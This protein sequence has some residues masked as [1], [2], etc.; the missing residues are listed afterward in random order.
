ML[1]SFKDFDNLTDEINRREADKI[2]K[3][4]K[5]REEFN[6]ETLD[7]ACNC[8]YAL[9]DFQTFLN[10]NVLAIGSSGTGKTR[11]LV[12]PN[13]K[14]AVGSSI[15][16]DPKGLIYNKHKDFLEQRGYNVL[17][18]DLAHPERSMKYNPLD[19][20]KT[21]QDVMRISEIITDKK[22][23]LGTRADPYWDNM[24][25][26]YLNAMIGYIIETNELPRCFSSVLTLM[27][28]GTRKDEENKITPLSQRF[29]RLK[30]KNPQSWAVS[31]FL[32]A[33][34][35]PYK[36]YDTIRS[37]VAAKFA[38]LDTPELRAM[39]SGNDIDFKRIG[40]EKTAVFVTV[41]DT[42][43]SMDTLANIFVTQSLQQLCEHAN[44]FADGRLPVP[45]RFI[46]DDF[47]T[48]C[49]IAEFPRI[50]ST[51]RSRGIS[52][53]L[54]LQSEAQLTNYYGYD[55][56][57]VISNCDTYVYLGGNDLETA[58]SISERANKPL[59]QI[60]NMP[61]GFCWVFRRGDPPVF[62]RLNR[63]GG[64]ER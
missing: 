15:L 13:L 39:M 54:M 33:D 18:L 57:T 52:A 9:N 31:Q 2:R 12:E 28:E 41:S 49:R 5:D 19:F 6:K 42:D 20:V 25:N 17:L 3:Q 50:I 55:D 40:E 60:L 36:T 48:N 21:P 34:S 22:A 58:K 27:H 24:T 43:R 7:I 53:M 62:T 51:I 8:R 10:N 35:A 16:I 14:K 37:T 46:L 32:N 11:T 63:V 45:V 26:I 44:D 29:A 38:N 61:V 4:E 56:K 30:L 59:A 1:D 64:R 23:S 47:A